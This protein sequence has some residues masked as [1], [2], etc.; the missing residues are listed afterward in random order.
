MGNSR[1]LKKDTRKS[2]KSINQPKNNLK[3][4]AKNLKDSDSLKTWLKEFEYW[5]VIIT[6][7]GVL[8]FYYAL[9]L[10]LGTTHPIDVVVSESMLPNLQ[11]G[12]LVVCSKDTPE[13]NDIIIYAGGRNFP[14][15]HR[16]IGINDSYC[17]EQI[18][19][20]TCYTIKGDNNQVRDPPVREEQVMCVVQVKI[21]Y[22]GYPRYLIFKV[23]GI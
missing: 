22:V 11:P 5:D 20:G 14:I 3:K 8:A 1:K 17:R 15:I 10:A 6:I 13:L 23:F 19:E 12:D 16:V 21:P 2:K 7:I 9:G 18:D 4:P